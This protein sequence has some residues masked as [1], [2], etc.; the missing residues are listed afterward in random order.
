VRKFA[1]KSTSD[2][3]SHTVKQRVRKIATAAG[4]T[5]VR[6]I[7]VEKAKLLSTP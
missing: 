2:R 3:N 1:V 5:A 6:Q 4:D 7:A